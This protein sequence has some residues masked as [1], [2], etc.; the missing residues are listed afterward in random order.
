MKILVPQEVLLDGV[1]PLIEK[2]AEIIRCENNEESLIMAIGDCD[3]VLARTEI[4]SRKVL[5]HAKKLKIL[6]RYGVGTEKIDMKAAN[7]LGI[8]VSN[9]PFALTNAVAEHVV[10]LL[11]S[12]AKNMRFCDK[13]LRKGDFSCRSTLGM[14]LLGKTIGIIG[15]GQ[16]GKA[17]AQK[18][19][20]GLGM[21]VVAYDPYIQEETKED[22]VTIVSQLQDLLAESDIVTIHLPLMPSTKGFANRA[23]FHA[24]KDGAIFINAARGGVV[25]EPALIE[26]L[27]SGKLFGAGLD[28]F[29][30]EPLP[31]D[32][33]LYQLDTVVMTPHNAS[34]T[35]DS[36]LRC[37]SDMGKCVMDVL[38]DG[39]R[40]RFAVNNPQQPRIG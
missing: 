13:N 22:N 10:L 31:L 15:F 6:A 29:S 39:K 2:G 8:W 40:P 12:V 1:Q 30:S 33:P 7:D 28:C 36:F 5:E 23:F 34:A 37:S 35:K 32:N 19:K 9:T 25:E 3:A 24:M 20:A 21:N 26:A 17:V 14:E 11:L 4:Y 38:L 18:C 27:K 16:I